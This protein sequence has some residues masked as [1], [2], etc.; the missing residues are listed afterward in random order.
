VTGA[1][2]DPVGRWAG[3]HP[4]EDLRGD[5]TDARV[6]ARSDRDDRPGPAAGDERDLSVRVELVVVDGPEAAAWRARQTAAIRA[7]LDWVT[8]QT[9]GPTADGAAAASGMWRGGRHDQRRAG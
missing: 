5:R 1:G 2:A 9:T 4:S 8:D 7:L 6:R 3:I